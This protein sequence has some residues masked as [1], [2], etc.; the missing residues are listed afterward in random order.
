[1]TATYA[2]IFHYNNIVPGVKSTQMGGAFTALGGDPAAIAFNPAGLA[3]STQNELSGSVQGFYNNDDVYKKAI[4]DDH[5]IETS[6]GGYSPFMGSIFR[7]DKH[8]KNTVVGF[9]L[10]AT[11]NSVKQ[12]N[13]LIID[14]PVGD[15][16]IYRYARIVHATAETAVKAGGIAKRW[17]N[18][19]VGLSLGYLT[20]NEIYQS[21]QNSEIV[22]SRS[23]ENIRHI[24]LES[25]F[26]NTSVK[27]FEPVFGALYQAS[28]NFSVGFA[29]RKPQVLT[30]KFTSDI[31]SNRTV[32]DDNYVVLANTDG[33]RSIEK[34]VNSTTT[35][36]K[37]KD[38]PMSLRFGAAMKP[39]E[40]YLL[41]ADLD[42]H[43]AAKGRSE[44]FDRLSVLNFNLGGE[45]QLTPQIALRGG[46][47]SNRDAR[48]RL[49]TS[50]NNQ[51]DHVDFLG[52]VVAG[53]YLLDKSSYSVGVVSQFGRGKA[54]KIASS[55][56]TPAALQDVSS[57]HL[58]IVIG[59]S[60]N[61]DEKKC[62][63]SATTK[64]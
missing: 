24:V 33:T 61:L 28:S 11:D 15:L 19:A 13:N 63:A 16:T 58:A 48:P 21:Y 55:D 14:Q 46:L 8:L 12:Q 30:E 20:I 64:G 3:F 10:Y 39:A 47:F 6:G 9:N 45:A 62:E 42:Y 35:N 18:F 31:D 43:S 56:D 2:D 17:D 53:E 44:D 49:S 25:V 32:T 38:L 59:I 60:H 34:Q 5:F 1:M 22:Q 50:K 29:V 41:A 36:S 26:Q 54:Q 51:D 57:T 4:G 7:V 23:G 27:A 52:L 40:G 37:M